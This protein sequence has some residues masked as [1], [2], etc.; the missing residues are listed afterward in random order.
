VKAAAH[1]QYIPVR[2][3]EIIRI[4]AKLVRPDPT[5][6]V[7]RD[8]R[9]RPPLAAGSGVLP[10]PID[11]GIHPLVQ[12]AGAF[13][14]REFQLAPAAWH[15]RQIVSSR[16]STWRI[17]VGD[18]ELRCGARVPSKTRLGTRMSNAG[19][20]RMPATVDLRTRCPTCWWAPLSRQKTLRWAPL[21][22]PPASRGHVP[23]VTGRG[24]ARFSA[25]RTRSFCLDGS[26]AILR[27]DDRAFY[28]PRSCQGS[29]TSTS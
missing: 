28:F 11:D 2:C 4:S 25:P 14:L 1:A 3:F 29:S 23:G 20:N 21:S 22:L 26:K 12:I 6:D 19:P 9:R 24:S 27:A 7:E 13:L 18:L 10:G 15:D 8:S 16:G 17:T 5:T